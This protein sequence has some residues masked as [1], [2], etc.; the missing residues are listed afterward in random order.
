MS[1]QFYALLVHDRPAPLESLKSA[2]KQLSIQTYSVQS[3]EEAKRLL[4]QTQPHVV[5]TDTALPD[6]SWTDV[7]DMAENAN[8]PVNVI[9]VGANKDIKLYISALERGAFDFVLPPFELQALDFVVQ[10]AGDNAKQ[11]RH[12]QARSAVA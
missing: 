11:R 3:C 8:S 9:V 12:A 4:P 10:S 7:V 1:D 2:L 5:F 6:G